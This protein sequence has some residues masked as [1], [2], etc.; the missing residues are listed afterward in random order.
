MTLYGKRCLRKG[1]ILALGGR[2]R[3]QQA[4]EGS[5]LGHRPCAQ[6][7]RHSQLERLKRTGQPMA[8]G[9]R[10]AATTDSERV[11]ESGSGDGEGKGQEKGWEKILKGD[12][13]GKTEGREE[14]EWH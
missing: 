2:L 13:E 5:T 11:A 14:G 9:V 8:G 10:M 12:D 1:P 3:A 6:R 7:C 4:S